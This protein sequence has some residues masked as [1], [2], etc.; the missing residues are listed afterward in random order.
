[1]PDIFTVPRRR[2]HDAE[3]TAQP[4]S[5][6]V[7][8][9]RG[10]HVRPI[11]VTARIRTVAIALV[12]IATASAA[13]AHYVVEPGDTLSS[14]AV[15]HGVSVAKIVKANNITN[16]NLIR[17]GQRLAIPG[18]DTATTTYVVVPGDTLGAIARRHGTTVAAILA[19]NQIR[20]PNLIRPGQRLTIHGAPETAPPP[21]EI[22][23]TV[24]SGETLG[25]IAARYGVTTNAIVGANDLA[26]PNR[27]RIG[28]RLTIPKP[29]ATGPTDHLGI[30]CPVPGAIFINDWGFPRP[31]GRFHQGTDLF[32]PRGTP[33]RAPVAGTVEAVT[34]DVGGLQFWLHGDDGNLYIGTH[35]DRFGQVGRVSAGDVVGAVGDT[36]N[37]KGAKTHLHFEIMIGG[38]GVNPYPHL[39]TACR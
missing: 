7:A 15:A 17:V 19:T 37:A 21:A 11:P 31:G 16:V 24:K 14:I 2:A 10:R 6:A 1:M 39:V 20:N 12:V 35:M 13:S 29:R 32:A 25:G 8:P 27:I 30:A 33:V 4:G 36:G 22:I 3:P 5:T 9:I 38:K 26:D 18:V 28:Q 23:H 34:G